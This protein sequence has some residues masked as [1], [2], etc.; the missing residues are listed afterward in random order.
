MK[1]F[2]FPRCTIII[3]VFAISALCASAQQIILD[4]P[5]RVGSLTVFPDLNDENRYYY[6]TDKPKLA[7]DENG[8]PQ[9]SFIRYVEN[10]KS[11]AST[12]ET[13]TEGQ[14]GG[15]IHA[16]VELSVSQEQ[17]D[18][19]QSELA[20]IKPNARIEGPI[21]F[22]SGVFGLVSAF[23]EED[24]EL[25]RRVVGL[26][27]APILDGHKAAI[28]MQ[29]TKLGAK[30]LWESFR[31]ATPDVSFTFEMQLEGY[32][33]PKRATIEAN[34]DQIYDHR[35]FQLG[36]AAPIL[37]GEIKDAFD[38]LQNSGAIKVTQ[39]GSDESM[40]ALINTAYNKIMEMMFQPAT[41]RGTPSL[42]SLASSLGTNNTSLMDRATAMLR[43]NSQPAATT[44]RPGTQGRPGSTAGPGSTGSTGTT[45]TPVPSRTDTSGH[46]HAD[47]A[48]AAAARALGT[49]SA[50]S[51]GSTTQPSTGTATGTGG[52]GTGTGQGQGFDF[53]I[54][55]S[56]EMKKE[57]KRGSYKI[58]LNKWTTDVI[59]IRIDE[60]IG[61]LTRYMD[62]PKYFRSIN[63]DDPVFRQRE[64]FAFVD[65]YNA[66]DFGQ[67]INFVNV[68][69]IKKHQGGDFTNDE[70]K[71]DRFNFNKSGNYFKMLY[72]WKEDNDRSKWFE[73]EYE[74][75]WSF[76]GGKTIEEPPKKT[77]FGAISLVPP[78]QRRTID[79]RADP[80]FLEG[81]RAILITLYFNLGDREEV[82]QVSMSS[83][84]NFISQKVDFIFPPNQVEYDYEITWRIRDESGKSKTITS[85]RRTTNDTI[86][87][88]DEIP[89]N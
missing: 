17:R 10:V 69:L 89:E 68:R 67:F 14:G 53:A 35:N 29:L 7:L 66:D 60:N 44:G 72:G 59:P 82:K 56:Y 18:E 50:T 64:I 27:T 84:N 4:K 55:A 34:F 39:I 62:D 54:L 28:S 83:T 8:N 41:S 58:E 88:V 37:A 40:D 47:S 30:I 23:N 80:A 63:L 76:F 74:I 31:M 86:L 78:L 11:S 25:G 3:L 2:R 71:I 12:D 36:V 87:F 38:D 15:I 77:T 43:R 79:F 70:V 32:R 52:R 20:R 49:G 22:K 26:G 51:T 24:G 73:Y 19:A 81:V 16:V 85:G 13:I 61:D 33:L 46:V 48:V 21:I 5:L 65:G 9:F 1:R 57:R 45:G 6:L 75:Q 42:G